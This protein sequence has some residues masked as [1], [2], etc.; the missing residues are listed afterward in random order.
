MDGMKNHELLEQKLCKE[1][2]LIESKYMNNAGEMSVQDVEKL[3]K[4]YHTLKS[5]ATY[6]AM[7]EAEGYD[8]GMSGRRGRGADGR[9]VSRDSGASYNEGYERGYSEAM[10]HSGHYPMMHYPTRW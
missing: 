3:D 7:K 4:I 9:Y 5:M 8:E 2:E 1:I 6:N 10:N